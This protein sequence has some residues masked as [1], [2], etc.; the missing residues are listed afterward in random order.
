MLTVTVTPLTLITLLPS[1]LNFLV[2]IKSS[3]SIQMSNSS[4]IELILQL[5]IVNSALTAHS[6]CPE[7]I[8]VLSAFAPKT[9]LR[10]S[11]ITDFPAPVS[12]DKTFSP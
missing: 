2:I 12:P 11:I 10:D 5:S 1:I 6:L 9:K 7:R 4:H 8:S 3:S